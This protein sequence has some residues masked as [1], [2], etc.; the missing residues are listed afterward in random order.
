MNCFKCISGI[1]VRLLLILLAGFSV[2]MPING[3][4]TTIGKVLKIAGESVSPRLEGETLQVLFDGLADLY[5]KAD[6]Q[7][8]NY[9][10]T[11]KNGRL[12]T[13][14][15]PRKKGKDVEDSGREGIISILTVVMHDAPELHERIKSSMLDRYELVCLMHDYH[16]SVTGSAAGIVYELPPPV[17]LPHIGFFAGYNADFITFSDSDDL[18]GLEPDP[19]FYPMA[20][21]TFKA[22]LPRISQKLSLTLD[23]SAGKRYVYGYYDSGNSGSTTDIYNEL[24]L[25]NYLI[26]ADVLLGY[27]F[28]LG[29]LK[30]FASGGI[31]TRTIISDNSRIDSDIFSDGVVM[32]DIYDYN[33]S[34]KTSMGVILSLGLSFDISDKVSM[35]TTVN[36]SE[37]FIAPAYGSYRSAGL[38]LGANF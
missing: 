15:V 8:G 34:E 17:F 37:L 28:G 11:D 30:P 4:G 19:A 6:S 38:K 14:S 1:T 35:A 16:V 13:L 33:T 18:Y 31:C 36:Y 2:I 12:F 22:S 3:Q 25:H 24:H 20:G 5:Y 23:L 27:K 21:I 32:S 9:Y 26:S 10:I 29:H 7:T